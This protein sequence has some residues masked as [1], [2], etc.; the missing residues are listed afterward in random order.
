MRLLSL[1]AATALIVAA[2]GA[3]SAHNLTVTN[4]Q[5]GE[6]IHVQWV[7]GPSPL[8]EQ[9]Q[10]EGLFFHPPSGLN[11]S[12]GHSQGLPNACQATTSSPTVTIT[13]PPF[14]TGCVHGMP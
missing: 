10:G 6:Q 1:M 5:T 14:F 12:A 7:G 4:P 3:A 9:A 8:P 11:Q 2:A 13:A